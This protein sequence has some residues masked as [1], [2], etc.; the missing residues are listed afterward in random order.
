VWQRL[1]DMGSAPRAVLFS[2]PIDSL[3]AGGLIA[4]DLW[5][6][7]RIVVVDRLGDE[8]LDAVAHGDSITVSEDGEVVISRPGG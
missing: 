2:R 4:A 1:V 7:G 5:A 8:F 3:A 6:G